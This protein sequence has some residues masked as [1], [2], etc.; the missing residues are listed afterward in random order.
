NEWIFSTH[1]TRVCSKLSDQAW[2]NSSCDVISPAALDTAAFTASPTT[3]ISIDSDA[4]F[5]N[6]SGTTDFSCSAASPEPNISWT[7]LGSLIT[8]SSSHAT[9][10]T[11]AVSPASKANKTANKLRISESYL[12]QN[13]VSWEIIMVLKNYFR[14]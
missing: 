12:I 2:S 3:P 5:P 14:W 1:P 11:E 7:C 13:R 6:A 9:N 4:A 8:P 10:P